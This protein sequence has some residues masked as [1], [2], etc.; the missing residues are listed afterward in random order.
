MKV[1]DVMTPL[2]D[3]SKVTEDRSIYDAV[4]M[5]DAIRQGHHRWE[6]APRFVLVYDKDF[7]VIGIVRYADILRGFV[8]GPHPQSETPP[9]SPDS[10]PSYTS[11]LESCRRALA[12]MFQM[13]RTIRVRDVMHKYIADDYIDEE[14]PIEEGLCRLM[15]RPYVNLVVNSGGTNTG[16]LRLSDIFR[17]ICKDIKR[18]GLK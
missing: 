7:T 8:P 2:V 15:V 11:E 5:L 17:L 9:E 1:K 13:S 10:S 3:C 6:D 12:D 16:I 4:M 14:A 18:S